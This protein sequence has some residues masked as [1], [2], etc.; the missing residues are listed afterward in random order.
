MNHFSVPVFLTE[1]HAISLKA[2]CYWRVHKSDTYQS[3]QR[4]QS[5]HRS[6]RPSVVQWLWSS[7]AEVCQGRQSHAVTRPE[8]SAALERPSSSTTSTLGPPVTQQPY[9]VRYIKLKLFKVHTTAKPHNVVYKTNET[10]NRKKI[11][12]KKVSSE[13]FPENKKHRRALLA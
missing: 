6:R 12:G 7:A 1:C 11:N 4:V 10:G 5:Y 13:V 3:E 2:S 8:S 9:Q